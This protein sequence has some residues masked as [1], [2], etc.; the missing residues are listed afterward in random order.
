MPSHLS[1]LGFAVET[2]AE[3]WELAQQVGPE[4]DGLAVEGG[5]YFHWSDGPVELWLQ[6]TRGEQFV[7]LN[8]HYFGPSSVIARLTERVPGADG[9][10]LDG[11]FRAELFHSEE[12]DEVLAEFAFDSPEFARLSAVPLPAVVRLQLAA[13]AHELEVFDS[14]E[15]F[16]EAQELA[17]EASEPALEP[18][19]FAAARPDAGG[20][21]RARVYLTG[22]ILASA[23]QTNVLSGI[24]YHWAQVAV[25]G[26]PGTVDVVCDASLWGGATLP[27]GGVLS[28][29]FWLSGRVRVG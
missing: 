17:R 25:L 3:F 13:F 15:S 23:E 6:V 29:T 26:G 20:G 8:P 5:T 24:R 16:A 7:G 19:H 11:G 1:T 12:S 4:S 22:A 9:N 2:E 28:G 18:T 21:G 14:P 27:E 10:P